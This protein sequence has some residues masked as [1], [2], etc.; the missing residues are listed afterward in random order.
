[1]DSESSVK[2]PLGLAMAACLMLL[3]GACPLPVNEPELAD[4]GVALQVEWAVEEVDPMRRIRAY[5][6]KS[7]RNGRINPQDWDDCTQD[8]LVRLFE[9]IG[10]ERLNSAITNSESDE[11]RE[12]NRAVWATA[13]RWRRR[14]RFGELNDTPDR[15]D[16]MAYWPTVEESLGSIRQAIDSGSVALSPVQK[17]I[18]RR[19]SCGESVASISSE[20]K[21]AP[22]R[23]SDE[24]YKAIRK[25]KAWF[26]SHESA[27][28]TG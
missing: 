13:Q 9:S 27:T 15:T 1:M 14:S 26:V 20:L 18:L 24:K 3:T 21:L 16:S 17:D 28:V 4:T 23:I 22:A 11:R 2:R 5:C 10:S 25:L 12:L 8:V 19:W 7:W 6:Q